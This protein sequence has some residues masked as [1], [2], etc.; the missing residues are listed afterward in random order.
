MCC[1]LL[2]GRRWRFPVGQILSRGPHAA[3]GILPHPRDTSDAAPDWRRRARTERGADV[4][5]ELYLT[6]RSACENGEAGGQ[7]G[8]RNGNR[9]RP[10]RGPRLSRASR[11]TD[12]ANLVTRRRDVSRLSPLRPRPVAARG[13]PAAPAGPGAVGLLLAAL[14]LELA[15]APPR[16]R[17]PSSAGASGEFP[18]PARA[19]GPPAAAGRRGRGD[20][21]DGPSRCFL[22]RLWALLPGLPAG[23]RRQWTAATVLPF[24]SPTPSS[25]SLCTRLSSSDIP[26]PCFAFL[27]SSFD[28]RLPS[29]P[30][31]PPA[32]GINL[33]LAF[34]LL[35]PS[36][37]PP[38]P[39][40]SPCGAA[41]LRL[42]QPRP[43]SSRRGL[44][45]ESGPGCAFPTPGQLAWAF[46]IILS[47]ARP[48]AR[49]SPR[50]LS[51][52]GGSPR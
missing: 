17:R 30:G 42:P 31:F 29:P 26:P 4:W 27:H 20:V 48:S 13:N 41:P 16:A 7:G 32:L 35:P 46:S 33:P 15:P 2:P 6:E 39:D 37:F 8:N 9:P 23:Q 49:L 10:G 28:P 43:G 40:E 47:A 45:E 38:P 11:T 3:V 25:R 19:G 36:L 24:V 22:R 50:A 5:G 1:A 14:E 52:N 21:W 18:V 34:P 12:L 51:K 44:S